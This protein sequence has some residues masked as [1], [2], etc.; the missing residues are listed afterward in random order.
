MNDNT[1]ILLQ[2]TKVKVRNRDNSYVNS[3]RVLF[4]S[5]SQLS[6]NTLQ[7]R[8]RLKLK[9]VSTT[10]I[11]I[12]TFG[13]NCSENISE[14]VNLRILALDRSEIC[15]TN[16]VKANCAPLNNQNINLGKENFPY[17]KNILLANSNPS[18]ESLSVDI[19]I[20]GTITGQL[21]ITKL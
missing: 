8:N 3:A 21:L 5:C 1:N 16:F 2:T 7:L 9:T 4:Y 11:S 12:Q 19:L 10:K 13:N 14:K 17:I 18:N 6:Y 20:G 15:V